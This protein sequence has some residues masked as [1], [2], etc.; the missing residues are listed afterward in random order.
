VS[1]PVQ[2]DVTAPQPARLFV[3]ENSDFSVALVRAYNDWHIDEWCAAY[4]G[5]FIPMALPAIWDR[6]RA[7]DPRRPS[8]V[9][10]SCRV[11]GSGA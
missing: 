5:R 8:P 4:P 7:V 1:S 9:Q 10:V 11:V 2:F 3:T 6:S